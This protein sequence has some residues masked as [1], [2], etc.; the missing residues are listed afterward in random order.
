[1]LA[2]VEIL[3]ASHLLSHDQLRK[4]IFEVSPALVAYDFPIQPGDPGKRANLNRS[5]AVWKCKGRRNPFLAIQDSD[6][7]RINRMS[8]QSFEL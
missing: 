3:D 5:L 1:V 6:S 2:G 8:I 7:L 4:V